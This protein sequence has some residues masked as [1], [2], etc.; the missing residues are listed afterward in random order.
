[1]LRNELWFS[2]AGG[3]LASACADQVTYHEERL[4][5]WE[6]EQGQAE[7]RLRESGVEFRVRPVT[8][9]ERLDAVVDPQRQA[10]LNECYAKVEQHRRQVEDFQRWQRSFET[11]SEAAFELDAED[12][13]YFGL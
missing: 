7:A 13:A 5:F 6:A 4:E 2:Y 9:G 11:N 1:M 3:V 10:R 8:G 12:V